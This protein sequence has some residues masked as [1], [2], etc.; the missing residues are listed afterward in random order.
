MIFYMLGL[1]SYYKLANKP[2]PAGICLAFFGVVIIPPVI[3]LFFLVDD[4]W[5]FEFLVFIIGLFSWTFIEYFIHRFLLH[6]KKNYRYYKDNHSLHHANPTEIFTSKLKRLLITIAAI[7]SVCASIGYSFYFWIVAG[8][9]CGYAAYGYVHTFLHT[10]RLSKWLSKLRAFHMQHHLS[11]SGTCFGVCTTW[12]DTIF[13][14]AGE[15][16]A[17]FHTKA[18]NLFFGIKNKIKMLL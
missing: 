6:G 16:Q 17:D 3:T 18:R 9:L 10:Q 14:T 5:V 2:V 12:W 1:L 4:Y 15:H 8:F 13:N 11:Q 7:L